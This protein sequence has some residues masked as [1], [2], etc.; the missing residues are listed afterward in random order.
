M[1]LT[2]L[3]LLL[4]SLRYLGVFCTNTNASFLG[5]EIRLISNG[6]MRFQE[7]GVAVE[8]ARKGGPQMRALKNSEL[9]LEW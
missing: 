2:I 1:N 7:T 3:R 9:A 4:R 6:D 5:L 8:H